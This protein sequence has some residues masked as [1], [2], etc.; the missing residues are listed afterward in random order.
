MSWTTP[1]T[2]VDGDVVTAADLNAITRVAVEARAA[3]APA[4][5]P[6]LALAAGAAAA[7]ELTAPISRRDVL[8]G[9]LFGRR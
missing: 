5:S 6:L 7:T 1:K 4:A 8:L 9:R 2:F 3:A